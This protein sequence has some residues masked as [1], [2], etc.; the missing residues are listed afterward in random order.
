MMHNLSDVYTY[1]VVIIW[2]ASTGCCD[3]L[4]VRAINQW[5]LD[6][7]CCTR[8]HK[9]TEAYHGNTIVCYQS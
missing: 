6:W 7:G 9:P 3:N 4:S 2:N 5:I 1:Y 8:D